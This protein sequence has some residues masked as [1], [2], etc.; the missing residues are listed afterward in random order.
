MF[1]E[2]NETCTGCIHGREGERY[3]GCLRLC[4]C[5]CVCAHQCVCVYQPPV[6]CN[7]QQNASIII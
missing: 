3:T 6:V 1:G 2:W 7:D 4:E 5:T